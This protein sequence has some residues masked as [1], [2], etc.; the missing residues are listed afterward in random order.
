[1]AGDR[2]EGAGTAVNAMSNMRPTTLD[3]TAQSPPAQTPPAQDRT[4]HGQI[5]NSLF[6]QPG[7]RTET[8][9]RQRSATTRSPHW[10]RETTTAGSDQ[11]ETVVLI[12]DPQQFTR[13]T[14]TAQLSGGG[15][16]RVIEAETVSGAEDV[17]RK[18]VSGQVAL[19]SMG[20][21]DGSIR[22]IQ[23]LRQAGWQRVIALAP[24]TDAAPVLA[25]MN[26]GASGILRGHPTATPSESDR[27]IKGLSE[28]EIEVL[29]LVADGRSNKW[30]AER[31]T[32]S[33]LT[34]KSHLAR[35]SRKLGTGDRSHLVAIAMRA[36]VIS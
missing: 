4:A 5:G 3:T 32:L 2:G 1:M 16:A 27:D 26:A 11:P 9:P 25:A 36:G 23:D 18:G 21:G 33:P 34:V 20:F 7:G 22:L 29:E 17:I 8:L 35:I 28:R 31:L 30:I 12:A 13:Q 19:V 6:M 24:T 10:A 15:I 14:L